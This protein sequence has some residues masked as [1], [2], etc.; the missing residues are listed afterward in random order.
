[1]IERNPRN[2]IEWQELDETAVLEVVPEIDVI[3][4]EE[5]DEVFDTRLSGDLVDDNEVLA[6]NTNV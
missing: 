2:F 3:D 6:R 5:V 4:G 1:M